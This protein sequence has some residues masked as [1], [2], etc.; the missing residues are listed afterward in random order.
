MVSTTT[1][2]SHEFRTASTMN[3]SLEHP[4]HARDLCVVARM[5]APIDVDA[6]R[7]RLNATVL[8][9]AVVTATTLESPMIVSR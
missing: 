5:V 2:Y 8:V 1:S 6:V 9:D 4:V 3:E 7:R